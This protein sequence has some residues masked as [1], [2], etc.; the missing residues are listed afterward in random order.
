MIGWFLC[1]FLGLHW[2]GLM[3]VSRLVLSREIVY[4]TRCTRCGRK[5]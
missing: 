4:R 5:M 2:P 3:K 1:E